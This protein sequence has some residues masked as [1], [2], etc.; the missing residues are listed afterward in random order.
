MKR[1]KNELFRTFSL[2]WK[3]QFI[4]IITVIFMVVGCSVIARTVIMRSNEDVLT[5]TLG[6]SMSFSVDSLGRSLKTA[7][8]LANLLYSDSVV[9]EQ[10][11]NIHHSA[12]SSV[13]SA[14]R[15]QLS[16]VLLRYEE[17]YQQSL[18]IR[19]IA[20]TADSFS[21]ST[22]SYLFEADSDYV[23]ETLYPQAGVIEGALVVATRPTQE[24]TYLYLTRIARQIKG[25]S[26]QNIGYVTLCLDLGQLTADA[27][28]FLSTYDDTVFML[29][30]GSLRLYP[31][32]EETSGFKTSIDALK[33]DYGVIR[34]GNHSWF[35]IRGT[36][37]SHVSNTI[38]DYRWDYCC[39]INYD[40]YTA[41]ANR[42]FL[43]FIVLSLLLL[44]IACFLSQQLF[45]PI[46]RHLNYLLERMQSFT[47]TNSLQKDPGYQ[48]RNDEIG[49]LHRQ[50]E[51]LSEKIS[52]LIRENYEK[53]LVTR[54][55]QL[56]SLMMQ[57]NP[58][59]LYNVLETINWRSQSAGLTSVST[60]VD[61]LGKLMRSTISNDKQIIP[62]SQELELLQNYITIQKIRF[63]DE[64]E[65]SQEIDPIVPDVNVPKMILQPLV[66]NAIRYGMET[67]TDEKCRVVVS[68][69]QEKPDELLITVRNTGSSFDED[70]I[71]KIKRKE[72]VA[73]GTGVGLLNIHQ[74]IHLL[75]GVQYGL[76]LYN[77]GDWA[78]AC[79]KIPC[80]IAP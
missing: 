65:Y 72:I 12:D 45:S 53:E 51:N 38:A 43:L 13:R 1:G 15:S 57:V 24:T 54:Q 60:M 50:F 29:Y 27:A 18:R 19:Y 44:L 4:V 26:L 34:S 58:H 20:I 78:V 16:P 73:R 62:L 2:K 37:H 33:R 3:V 21:Y 71:E 36:L 74:R 41:Q 25:F 59:F 77:D 55:A 46:S 49:Q 61:A 30:D 68:I 6:N 5:R 75:Y 76:S 31:L 56:K 70:L 22:N 52:E 17:Q 48:N 23:T 39:L 80:T 11:V 40:S 63:E 42:T 32:T 47:G 69:H 64:L 79:I 8:T 14:A 28:S 7:E 35:A 10:L 9:Q 67:L 66:D